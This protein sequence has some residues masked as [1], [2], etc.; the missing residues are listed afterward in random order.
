MKC[1][2]CCKFAERGVYNG[3]AEV[4]DMMTLPCGKSMFSEDCRKLASFK[5]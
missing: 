5:V 3:N 4:K 2:I 1:G